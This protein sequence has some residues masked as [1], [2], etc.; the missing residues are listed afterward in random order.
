M[1]STFMVNAHDQDVQYRQVREMIEADQQAISASDGADHLYGDVS[2][3]GTP[4]QFPA[5]GEHQGHG[6]I[7]M[8]TGERAKYRDQHDKP[9]AGG[10]RV[11]QK[12]DRIIAA[13]QPLSHD[14]GTDDD[15]QQQGRAEQFGYEPARDAD[16]LQW[17]L[18]A[19]VSHSAVSVCSLGSPDR[20]GSSSARLGRTLGLSNLIEVLLQREAVEKGDR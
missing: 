8:R 18:Q 12:G 7:E 20:G 15:G 6:R 4:T 5:C 2:G 1:T 9:G 16:G 19:G 13:R 17:R 3:C 11:S 14:P 10:E